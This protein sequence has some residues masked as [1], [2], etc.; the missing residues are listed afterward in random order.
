MTFFGFSAAKL[1]HDE[2]YFQIIWNNQKILF[3]LHPQ[4]E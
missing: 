1:Q 3:S 4:T 2:G